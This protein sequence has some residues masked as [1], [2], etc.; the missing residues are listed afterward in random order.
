MSEEKLIYQADCFGYL[1]E[2]G[3][4]PQCKIL[5]DGCTCEG[6]HFYKTR[7]QYAAE[8]ERAW[9]KNHDEYY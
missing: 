9:R 2:P 3:R 1:K 8:S 4:R 7:E 5:K 6:C